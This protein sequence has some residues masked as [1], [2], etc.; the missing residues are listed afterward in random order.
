MDMMSR[1]LVSKCRNA[2]LL[3]A[4]SLVKQQCNAVL[5]TTRTMQFAMKFAAHLY[6]C[7]CLQLSKKCQEHNLRKTILRMMANAV[8]A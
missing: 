3:L 2:K 5:P 8:T 4:L 1:F 6:V 7:V